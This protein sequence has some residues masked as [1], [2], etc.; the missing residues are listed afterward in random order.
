M[1]FVNIHGLAAL[2]NL[3]LNKISLSKDQVKGVV[4]LARERQKLKKCK[5]KAFHTKCFSHKMLLKSTNFFSSSL[6]FMQYLKYF[7]IG[8]HHLNVMVINCAKN[9]K[10]RQ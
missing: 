5:E 8:P 9:K 3:Q 6:F 2:T 10:T 7:H 4:L 1:W